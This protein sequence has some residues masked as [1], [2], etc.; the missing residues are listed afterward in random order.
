MKVVFAALY[1]PRDLDR[2]SG[3]SHFLIRELERQGHELTCLAVSTVPKPLPTRVLARLARACGKRYRG[4]QDPWIGRRMGTNLGAC[5]TA[6]APFDVLLTNDPTLAAYTPTTRPVVLY[7]DAIF[8]PRYRDNIHPWLENLS[9]T[10]VLACQRIQ[11]LALRRVKRACFASSWAGEEALGYAGTDAARI[12]VIPYGA[13][14]DPP[15][16]ELGEKRCQRWRSTP[17]PPLELLFI[18][19]DWQLKGGAIAVA[20][21]GEL[22]RRKIAAQLHV[23]GTELPSDVNRRGIVEHGLLD[24]AKPAERQRLANL[25]VRSDV[26]L[27]PTRAEG[28]GIVFAE[29]AAHSLPSLACRTTGVETAVADGRSGVLV[30]L[31]ADAKTFADVIESWYRAPE[32]Y[33]R[34]VLGARQHYATTV[35]WPTAVARL[36]REIEAVL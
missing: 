17:T 16:A 22:E 13:N 21:R 36:C 18:G 33:R 9:A 29:A 11:S 25:L 7:T 10:S 5:L 8:P 24:K 2:G 20:T 28:F 23:V 26:F 1:D 34:L 31:D 15:T 14:L 3:T 6:G 30:E 19:R 35:N 32:R 4:H 27:L 12:L